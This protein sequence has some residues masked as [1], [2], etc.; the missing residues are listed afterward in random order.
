[1]DE[2]LLQ[3]YDPFYF[4][5][6]KERLKKGVE[7]EIQWLRYYGLREDRE[8]LD[9]SKSIYE[10]VRSIGYTKR[11]VPL[12]LRCIGCLSYQWKE[13]LTVENLEPLNERRNGIDR[14]TPL[15]MWVKLYPNEIETIYK[16]LNE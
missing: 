2:S 13:G 5:K 9:L 3:L 11:V 4:D 15:E 10:Q 12:D 6:M 8:K 14:F 1:M 16:L 7:H